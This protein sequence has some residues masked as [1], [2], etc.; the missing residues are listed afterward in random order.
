MEIKIAD[1]QGTENYKKPLIESEY[2]V[3]CLSRIDFAFQPIV[4]IHTGVCYGCEA[5]LR[6]YEEAGFRSIDDFFDQAYRD[7]ALY[8]VDLCLREKAVKKF[9]TLKWNRQ[10]KLF[11]N[12]DN[13]VLDS[14]N[15][16]S[17]NTVNIL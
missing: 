1:N 9:S 10:T 15:Y 16:K 17:G 3:E 7:R 12:L 14:E 5:L 2:W 8:S 11:I 6:N 13:R 4:N